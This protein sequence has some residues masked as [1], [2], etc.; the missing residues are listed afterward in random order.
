MELRFFGIA[1]IWSQKEKNKRIPFKLTFHPHNL[2]AKTVI[3]KMF[4]LL[5][6]DSETG[7]IFWQRPLISFKRDKKIGSF[8]VRRVLKSDDRPGTCKCTRKRRNTGPF[9]RNANNKITGSKWSIRINDLF[10]CASANF[11]YCIA[12]TYGETG[13]RLGDRSR[14]RLRDVGKK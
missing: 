6:N 3:L 14:K 13:R 11:F 4:M 2:A 1:F 12:F 5:Q 9:I 8:I 7:R 10:S